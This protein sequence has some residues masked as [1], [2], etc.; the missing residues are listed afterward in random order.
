M[1]AKRHRLVLREALVLAA[2]LLAGLVAITSAQ[3]APGEGEGDARVIK[4]VT[5]GFATDAL[6]KAVELYEARIG[7]GTSTGRRG[8]S[9]T[10]G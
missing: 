5:S 7:Q 1:L 9:T 8:C 6:E 4:A 3:M 10:P 2:A